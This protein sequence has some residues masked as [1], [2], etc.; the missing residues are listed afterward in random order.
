L[1][2]DD[3]A[4][5]AAS[6]KIVAAELAAPNIVSVT[7][8]ASGP[9][10]GCLLSESSGPWPPSLVLRLAAKVSGQKSLY[11]FGELLGEG[12][13]GRIFAA[14][15]ASDPAEYAVKVF[16]GLSSSVSANAAGLVFF[17]AVAKQYS[18]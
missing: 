8:S 3:V 10:V 16:R 11:Q 14:K 18:A 7:T 15:R 13:F 2:D 9:S 4:L 17:G 12:T 6:V 5:R 1:S